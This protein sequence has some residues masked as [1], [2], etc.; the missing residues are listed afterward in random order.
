[1]HKNCFEI[2][3][4]TIENQINISGERQ[5][6]RGAVIHLTGDGY[7]LE[8]VRRVLPHSPPEKHVT[9]RFEAP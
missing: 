1:M 7:L 4:G 3:T 9:E 2:L 6:F 8:P 5:C